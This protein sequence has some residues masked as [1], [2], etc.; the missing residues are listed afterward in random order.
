MPHVEKYAPGSFC[1]F[2]LATSDQNAAKSFYGSLFGWDTADMPMGPGDVYTMFRLDGRDA[3]AAYTLRPEM[4]AQGIPPNWTLYISVASADE[5]A[6]KAGQSGGQVVAPPFDVFD[7]GR[8]AAVIDPAGAAFCLWEEKRNYGAGI[9]GEPGAFCWADLCTK[10]VAKAAKFYSDVFGW[11][12]APG[13]QDHS[14]YL[15]IKNGDAFIGGMP[16]AAHQNPHVPPHWMLYFMVHNVA[17]STA[18]AVELG[19]KALMGPMTMEKVGDM[20]II[21]DPQD[22]TFALFKPAPRS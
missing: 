3:A 10:D 22:A 6:G 13:E 1:W 19:G 17:E 4:K 16:P 12:I 20:A 18:K 11:Q 14:G 9:I 7:I 2:E 5:T 15:H 21:A 8:M